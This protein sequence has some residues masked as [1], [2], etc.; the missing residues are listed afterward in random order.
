[1]FG[2]RT[3]SLDSA[4]SSQSATESIEENR[5]VNSDQLESGEKVEGT[6]TMPMFGSVVLLQSIK[7]DPEVRKNMRN[8]CIKSF[9]MN[10]KMQ[11][12]E[13]QNH[14]EKLDHHKRKNVME[15]EFTARKNEQELDYQRKVQALEL[16][17]HQHEFD[18]QQPRVEDEQVASVKKKRSKGDEVAVEI[19]C[20]IPRDNK[21]YNFRNLVRKFRYKIVIYYYQNVNFFTFIFI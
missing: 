4:Q 14:Y 10:L 17:K 16:G 20:E 19:C 6:K 1:M 21:I 8:M 2:N 7:D 9:K 3:G 13:L 15:L 5:S 11:K 18:F 12:I